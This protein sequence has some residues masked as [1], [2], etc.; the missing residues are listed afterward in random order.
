MLRM[1][2]AVT[3]KAHLTNE[4]LYQDLLEVTEKIQ[5]RK[6]GVAGQYVNP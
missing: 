2:M 4:Y 5:Q 6:V 3:R 1:P